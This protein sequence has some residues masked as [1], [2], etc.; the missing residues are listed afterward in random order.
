MK[1]INPEKH[2]QIGVIL[3]IVGVFI[4]S[5]LYPFT[6]L[7]ENGIL[8]RIIGLDKGCNYNPRI[9]D[10]EIVFIK[11]SEEAPA[12]PPAPS[13]EPP[14]SRN[15]APAPKSEGSSVRKKLTYLGESEPAPLPQKGFV[16]D[17]DLNKGVPGAKS[18]DIKISYKYPLAL[19]ILLVFMGVSILALVHRKKD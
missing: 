10:L 7:T 5:T 2:R 11:G 3:I 8:L 4:P 1:R 16:H 17:L 15:P 13:P 18:R 19:G 9:E 12:P 6:S 14:L